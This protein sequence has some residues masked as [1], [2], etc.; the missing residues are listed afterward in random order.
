MKN[1]ILVTGGLGILGNQLIDLLSQDIKNQVFLLD[2]NKNV[3]RLKKTTFTNK[4]TFIGG[5]FID[6]N[7][8]KSLIFRHNFKAI[9]HLG[10]VTQ[11]IDAY[12]SP[13]KTF[14][15]NID[16]ANIYFF[17]CDHRVEPRIIRRIFAI[18]YYKIIFCHL[19]QYSLLY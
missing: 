7:K 15:T 2:Y 14:R 16:G 6:L 8:M 11:V 12:K 1:K 3:N 9:F 10:A 19:S 17:L 18:N 5:D 4:V 13:M